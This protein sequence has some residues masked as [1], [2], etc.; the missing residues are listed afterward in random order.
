M[1]PEQAANLLR[2]DYFLG[3]IEKLR[4]QQI[5]LILNSSEQDI[6]ARENA[7]RMIKALSVIRSHF[8]SIADTKEIE[9]KRWKIL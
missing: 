9:R 1:S 6:D 4:Q 8:Q 3:E 7:Y 2:D 5:D